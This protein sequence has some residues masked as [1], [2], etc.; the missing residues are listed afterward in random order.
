ML[1]TTRETMRKFGLLALFSIT[2]ALL[3]S[4]SGKG[5]EKT[6]SGH[7]DAA[8]DSGQTDNGNDADADGDTDGDVD[9]DADSDVDGDGDA[10]GDAAPAFLC[11]NPVQNCCV[12]LDWARSMKTCPYNFPKVA[13]LPDGSSIVAGKF[14]W[15]IFFTPDAGL[16]PIDS[17]QPINLFIA[18]YNETGRF[19]WAKQVIADQDVVV[20][21]IDAFNDGSFVITGTFKTYAVFGRG[22]LNET[23]LSVSDV[24]GGAISMFLAR[25]NSDGILAWATQSSG[26]SSEYSN[27]VSISGDD[28]TY[29]TGDFIGRATFG[30]GES[31]ETTLISEGWRDIFLARYESGGNLLWA[32]S[33]SGPSTQDEQGNS[34]EDVS[35]FPDGST[36]ILGFCIHQCTFGKGQIHETTLDDQHTGLFLA[37]YENDGTFSWVK[38]LSGYPELVD[39]SADG[40]V[41][42]IGQFTG[43]TT[44][45][46]GEPNETSLTAQ[47]DTDIFLARLNLDGTLS[48]VRDVSSGLDGTIAVEGVFS[49]NDASVTVG[50]GSAYDAI[51]GKGEAQETCLTA[52]TFLVKYH[53]DGT[54]VWAKRTSDGFGFDGMDVSKNGLASFTESYIFDETMGPGDPNQTTLDVAPNSSC[55]TSGEIALVR[56]SP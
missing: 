55:Y 52:G 9:G 50:G 33:I 29:I 32:R 45:G 3:A 25:Y 8:L 44:F 22:E 11:D 36:L 37:R 40:T 23:R 41:F 7:G 20:T 53:S 35:V 34:A 30:Q 10:D 21:G 48:W 27:A 47:G 6:D 18:K 38:T 13:L 56:F 46:P 28:T 2:L 26:I 12:H 15:E 39:C 16:H 4:C 1:D 54:L 51:F 43:S 5:G 19:L 49:D 24:T 14:E 42:V 31:G 17:S